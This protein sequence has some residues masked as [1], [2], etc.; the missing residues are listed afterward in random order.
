MLAVGAQS[1][2][3]GGATPRGDVVLSTR[4]LRGLVDRGPAHLQAGAGETLV[5]VGGWLRERGA[6]YPPGP[7]FLGATVGGTIATNAAGAATFKYGATRRWVDG[8]TVVLA[9]GEVLDLARGACVAHVDG[10]FDVALSSHT[11][12]VPVPD[13]AMPAVPK[14]SAGYFAAPGMDLI[15]LFIGCEG[16]LGIV[17]DA[18]LRYLSPA[19]ATC[20]VFVTCR[21]QS[22]ALAF[23]GALRLASQQTWTRAES[24]GLDVSAIEYMDSRS[25]ALLREDG[26][27]TRLGVSLDASAVMALLIA[28]DLPAGTGSSEVYDALGSPGT[29]LPGV[30]HLADLLSQFGLTDDVVVAP[31]DD[32]AGRDRL[33]ALREAVPIAVNARVGRARRD[34]DPR[35]EKTA[36]DVVVPF[37][38]LGEWL[39]SCHREWGRSE[40][41]GAIWGHVSD[42]NV[43]PNVIPGCYR[44]VLAGKASMRAVGLEAIRLGGAPLA[45]HGVGRNAVK[46]LLLA[47][48][49]CVAGLAQMRNVKRALDPEWKLAPGVLFPVE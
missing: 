29:G 1:S 3:T 42:G 32:V 24:S 5:D 30:A 23:V 38:R 41:D 17:T 44:D 6:V 19:P 25:L 37:E 8:L 45:E 39:E 4:G 48:L 12:R 9:C 47:D 7:T 15:D 31:P 14:L 40:L 10:Y 34:V 13:Y 27:D 26:V 35:I 33:L 36:A 2:L 21:D 11:V 16:T 18:T 28:L 46:Q 20:L 43:H 49:Y 22:Q